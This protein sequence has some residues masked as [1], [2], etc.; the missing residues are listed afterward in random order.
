MTCKTLIVNKCWE[1]LHKLSFSFK[2]YHYYLQDL[3]WLGATID[4]FSCMYYSRNL[5]DLITSK[6]SLYIPNTH[7]HSCDD[8]LVNNS[9]TPVCVS[10]LHSP[11]TFK[12]KFD[13]T[14]KVRIPIINKERTMCT[15]I[16]HWGHS[17]VDR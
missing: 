13:V 6:F 8:F 16:I 15:I 4:M 2:K 7:N 5:H 12:R 1:I 11:I 14:Y 9:S 17:N 10:P 3:Y